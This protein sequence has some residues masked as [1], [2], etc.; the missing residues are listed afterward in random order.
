MNRPF[1]DRLARAVL[2]EGY[3]LYPY[4]PSVKNHQR[5][6]FGGLYPKSWSDAQD[7]TD[8]MANMQTECLISG[9]A[10][11]KLTVAVRFLHLIDR[12]VGKLP[13]PLDDVPADLPA[14]YKLVESLDVGGKQYQPWQEAAEREEHLGE[15]VLADLLDDAAQSCDR[16]RWAVRL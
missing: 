2:Y 15:F 4:R 7:G 8:A 5:W 11:A 10:N 9:S 1:V 12:T 3:I 6:T 13:E 14:N 16:G